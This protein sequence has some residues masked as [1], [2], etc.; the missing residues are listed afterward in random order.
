MPAPLIPLALGLM[1]IGGLG[2]FGMDQYAGYQRN[3]A[4]EDFAQKARE[5][6]A[7][8]D[9]NTPEG[10]QALAQ[11]QLL[12][13]NSAK[14][15]NAFMQQQQRLGQQ[16][17]QYDNTFNNISAYQQAG[18]DQRASANA[19]T[20]AKTNPFEAVN[21]DLLSYEGR[22]ADDFT[23]D[24]KD[25]VNMRNQVTPLMA[26]LA[27]GDTGIDAFAQMFKFIKTLDPGM[28]TGEDA[29]NFNA[30]RSIFSQIGEKFNKGLK[31]GGYTLDDRMI[32]AQSLKT[33]FDASLKSARGVGEHY[34]F[35]SQGDPT[36]GIPSFDPQRVIGSVDLSEMHL[37]EGFKKGGNKTAASIPNAPPG[38]EPDGRQADER[39]EFIVMPDGSKIYGKFP[40]KKKTNFSTRRSNRGQR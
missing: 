11:Q 3:N 1:G 14:Y 33:M 7:G 5:R 39:G 2:Q 24:T 28:V 4:L 10:R 32:M 38:F 29:D 23:R 19:A 9:L 34:Q 30:A 12:D 25:F 27:R 40:E 8:L 13:P 6:Q 15:G 31:G 36:R 22:V 17:S 20:L 18:L 16:Q 35:L 37:P 21:K 26:S